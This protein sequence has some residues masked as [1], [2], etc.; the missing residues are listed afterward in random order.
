[1]RGPLSAF[2]ALVPNTA[3]ELPAGLRAWGAGLP[4]APWEEVMSQGP[5]NWDEHLDP[6]AGWA[7]WA[8]KQSMR[9]LT[10]VGV[11]ASFLL[12][13]LGIFLI[14]SGRHGGIFATI[15]AGSAILFWLAAIPWAIRHGKL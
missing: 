13:A 2:S 9:R 14:A 12:L 6:N 15:L 4:P 11:A 3:W 7:P 5:G 1:M 8:N 10:G